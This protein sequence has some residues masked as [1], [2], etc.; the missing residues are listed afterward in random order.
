[1]FTIYFVR[2]IAI[3]A[4]HISAGLSVVEP[5]QLL[6]AMDLQQTCRNQAGD[7]P[8]I[9]TSGCAMPIAH[10]L[11]DGPTFARNFAADL[12]QVQQRFNRWFDF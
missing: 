8:L 7:R 5:E 1:M 9:H 6:M 3:F 10:A 2:K 4:L 11:G 12:L